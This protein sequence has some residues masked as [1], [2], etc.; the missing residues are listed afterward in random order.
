VWKASARVAAVVAMVVG[1]VGGSG[2]SAAHAAARGTTIA[3]YVDMPGPNPGALD[4]A[5]TTDG[6]TDF[7]AAFVIGKGCT[8]T[9]DDKT[10]VASGD[11]IAQRI[12][13]AR[14]EDA[15]P[16]VSFGGQAGMDLAR[17]CSS[18]QQIVAGY[19]AVIAQLGV[20]RVDFDIEGRAIK[21]APSIARRFDAI[22]D[23]EA[24]APAVSVSLTVPVGPSGLLKSGVKLLQTAQSMGVRVDLV[25]IMAMDYGDARD[26][27]AAAVSA[28]Q[29]T[30]AQMRKIWPA[31]TYA[32]LGVTPMIGVN[33]TAVE[34]FSAKNAKTLVKF[35]VTNGVGR[36][37][38]WSVNRDRKCASP[39]G[40]ARDDCSGAAQKPG[41]FAKS[42]AAAG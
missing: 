8:P 24:A 5:I 39:G 22:K 40:T 15:E 26:M 16:I 34:V 13:T 23:L 36:L 25:N 3:P 41:A 7:T 33:D 10:P 11:A 18:E 17:S 19:Q 27:G 2:F 32:N 6:L 14:D 20:D 38:F 29:G 42:F 9:W 30:L 31:S 35:A 28:A 1:V 21:D 12:A 4:T 37:G